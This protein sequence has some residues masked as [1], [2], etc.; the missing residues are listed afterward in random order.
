MIDALSHIHHCQTFLIST[1]NAISL[2]ALY[3]VDR[4]PVQEVDALDYL[5]S[6]IFGR[7][8][9]FVGLKIVAPVKLIF[10]TIKAILRR[11][12]ASAIA[13]SFMTDDI[14]RIPL[15]PFGTRWR[16]KGLEAPA[17]ERSIRIKSIADQLLSATS[18]KSIRD[19]AEPKV[20]A[21]LVRV[22]ESSI[23]RAERLGRATG[24]AGVDCAMG[25]AV[26]ARARFLPVGPLRTS[27]ILGSEP[28][29]IGL[30]LR[31]AGIVDVGR[32]IIIVGT[33]R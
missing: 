13:C 17:I 14:A 3:A 18:P 33:G 20:G 21:F 10:R 15:R 6:R 25:L 12:S 9:T 32:P 24:I 16:S 31:L 7:H 8:V 11:L 29:Q 27:G 30:G 22:R 28:R 5:V 23:G 1:F 19:L 26:D 2:P 4:K